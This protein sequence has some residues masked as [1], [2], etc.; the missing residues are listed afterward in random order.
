M[1][2]TDPPFPT[3]ALR[4]TNCPIAGLC[5]GALLVDERSLVFSLKFRFSYSLTDPS[6]IVYRN[7]VQPWNGNMT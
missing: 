6:G 2:A 3:R 1:E 7:L 5:I 4:R